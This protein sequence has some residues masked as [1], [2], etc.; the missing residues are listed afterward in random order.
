MELAE[1]SRALSLESAQRLETVQGV[2][3][4][5]DRASALREQ[6][7]AELAQIQKQQRDTFAQIEAADDQFSQLDMKAR[8]AAVPA[9]GG[10][11]TLR[12]VDGRMDELRRISDAMDRRI[13]GIVEREPVVEAVRRSIEGVHA[14]GQ[15]SQAD[16]EAISERR[17]EIPAPRARWTAS[18]T[19][20]PRPRNESW[21]SR[22]V[23]NWS[24]MCSAR[25][26]RSRTS[27]A[28]CRL[29]STASASR[30]RWS[31]TSSP[32]S[33]ASNLVQEA[34]GTMRALQ[35]ERD[36]AQRIVENVRQ[37][38]ARATGEERI[39]A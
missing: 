25:P 10:S 39:T 20:S 23:D 36:V 11:Q 4:E 32:S 18:A 29:R 21:P 13:Q 38:H 2:H 19:A 14:L 22:T 24:T 12:Q 7:V 3:Q 28:T 15:K 17:A 35:T 33:R 16:L 9:G 6:L 8:S 26:I 34:R 31:I 27:S 30:R 1:A 37:I 5:L